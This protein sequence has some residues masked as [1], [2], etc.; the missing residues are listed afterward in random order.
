[1]AELAQKS[2]AQVNAFTSGAGQESVHTQPVQQDV[3]MSDEEL[4]RVDIHSSVSSKLNWIL[5]E[6]SR[7]CKDEKFLIFSASPLTLA[8]IGDGLDLLG[9]SYL[10]F[11]STTDSK[12]REQMP[13]TFETASSCRVMLMELKYGARG[14]NLTAA[15]R[16][17]FCEPVWRA[18]VESQAIKRAHRIGQLK[19]IVV[20]T[21]AI[22]STF[23][24]VVLARRNTSDKHGSK[25]P[26]LAEEPGMRAFLKDPHFLEYDAA[27]DPLNSN[28]AP[29]LSLPSHTASV[30]AP[31]RVEI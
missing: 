14:L 29:L 12:V 17:I 20:K 31:S 5:R 22:R 19:P 16:V 24:E 7:Y 10:T 2:K 21:L 25:G 28:E 9:V 30:I 6:V 15:S 11:A 1:V 3:V 13:V 23:E 4:P 27:L 8:H 26:S 18:D